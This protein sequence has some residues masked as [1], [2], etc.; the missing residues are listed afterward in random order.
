MLCHSFDAALCAVD[1]FLF[2]SLQG[3]ISHW[4]SNKKLWLM[5]CCANCIFLNILLYIY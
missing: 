3:K 4:Y 5:F 2:S 1:L